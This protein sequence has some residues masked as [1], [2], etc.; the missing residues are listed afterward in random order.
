MALI[1][2]IAVLG[3]VNANTKSLRASVQNLVTTH[4]INLD[5]LF[6]ERP[7]LMPYFYDGRPADVKDPKYGEILAAAQIFA[8]TMELLSDQVIRFREQWEN[9]EGWDIWMDDTL[10]KSPVLVQYLRDHRTWYGE[11]L[12]KRVDRIVP[13]K[14]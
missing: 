14:P 13:P 12:M 2:F 3:S 7:Y 4:I 11:S 8:D 6:V 9:P 10:R 1:G 5:K